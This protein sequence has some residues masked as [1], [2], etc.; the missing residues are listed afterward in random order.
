MRNARERVLGVA[1]VVLVGAGLV[2][3]ASFPTGSPTAAGVVPA[4]GRLAVQQRLGDARA[5]LVSRAGNLELHV[6]YRTHKGWLG[7]VSKRAEGDTLAT[8]SGT[9]GVDDRIP[10]LSAVFGRADGTEVRV[11]WA[12]GRTARAP[13]AVD[14]T[15]LVAR[16]GR[17]ASELVEVLDDRGRPTMAL[18]GP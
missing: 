15:Y 12:D 13:T 3:I 11:R 17:V 14:G 4:D 8:W 1:V 10:A 5:L 18:P 2:A 9:R 6:A 16:Q 7:V